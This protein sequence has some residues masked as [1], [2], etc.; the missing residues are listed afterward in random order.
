MFI[1]SNNYTLIY[2]YIYYIS[3]IN[4]YYLYFFFRWN[5][6]NKM[7]EHWSKWKVNEKFI[8]MCSNINTN[9]DIVIILIVTFS[10]LPFSSMAD[11]QLPSAVSL[12]M[13][14]GLFISLPVPGLNLED[15]SM[16]ADHPVHSGSI[17]RYRMI[18]RFR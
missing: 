17:D 14:A 3:K 16:R 4:I 5:I 9:K 13:S 11:K 15:T 12:L 10:W 7:T 2:C 8:I 1:F 6:I 18:D